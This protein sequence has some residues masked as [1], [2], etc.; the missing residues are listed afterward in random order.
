[1]KN[2]TTVLAQQEKQEIIDRALQESV[3]GGSEGSIDWCGI[4]CS[5]FSMDVC[6]ID[7]CRI[8]F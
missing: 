6:N 8:S 4:S 1:M 5:I 3:G 7:L 2:E